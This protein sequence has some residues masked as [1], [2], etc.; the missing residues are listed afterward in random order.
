MIR[1]RRQDVATT[2]AVLVAAAELMAQQAGAPSQ[3]R[4]FR[5]SVDVVAVD[6]LAVDS[7]GRPLADLKPSDL[8]LKVDGKLREVRSLQFVRV[9][10]A[11][12]PGPAKP[13]VT[14]LPRPFADNQE[15]VPV[16][17]SANAPR[18]VL[19]V[20]D[21]E[22][23]RPGGSRVVPEIVNGFLDMMADGDR[24]GLV[25]MPNG[26]LE[27]DLT[28]DLALVRRTVANVSGRTPAPAAGEDFS[29]GLTEAIAV[30]QAIDKPNH[31]V[32]QEIADFV[33][34][35][36]RGTE[37]AS[38]MARTTA[39]V[40]AQAVQVARTSEASTH[41]LMMSLLDFLG[42][43]ASV[44]G[45]KTLVFVSEGFAP[46]LDTIQDLAKVTTAAGRSRVQLYAIQPHVTA[47][48]DASRQRM[49]K[50]F[51]EDLQLQYSGLKDLSVATGGNL[52]RLSG[53]PESAVARIG[54]ETSAYYLLGF[55]PAPGERDGKSHK[56]EVGV[57][58]RDVAVRARP[59]FTIPTAEKPSALVSA[60]PADRD[61]PL[62]ALAY[63]FR[64]AD[65]TSVKVVVVVEPPESTTRFSALNFSLTDPS[66]KTIA[67]WTAD[68]AQ[69]S[70]RPLV[71]ATTVPPGNYRVGVTAT[72]SDG[73]IGVVNYDLSA[74][75]VPV[76]SQRAG[77]LM[78]G[79]TSPAGAF[80][81]KLLFG[82]GD[83]DVTGYF[84][85]YGPLSN[86]L[87]IAWELLASPDG[88]ALANGPFTVSGTADADRFVASGELPLLSVAPGDYIVRATVSVNG[89][90]VGRL[91]RALRKK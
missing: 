13:P 19:F 16:E 66:G 9:G 29:I 6:F 80:A 10:S 53:T 22:H 47:I 79:V 4:T 3:V 72:D 84:E 49:P 14:A 36:N 45:P 27:V 67:A 43:L 46:Y 73:R 48:Q 30:S 65:T 18:A 42:G 68:A 26:R 40:A 2:V 88:P 8:T 52:M 32:V 1:V 62:R 23:I 89:A 76:G 86:E 12:T 28:P 77:A 39:S 25:T 87:T 91:S 58:R 33:C 44:D 37:Y 78:L 75:L 85:L 34:R 20:I 51:A 7:Q 54:R 17:P 31:P 55:E 38:C 61:L 56:I 15:N 11:E 24:A 59:E 71:S 64:G 21:H 5:S 63:P 90:V 81:P 41:A 74:G 35:F 83:E 50:S 69:L 60:R 70:A 57:Q 82:Q